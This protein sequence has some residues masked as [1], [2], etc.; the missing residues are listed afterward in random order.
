MPARRLQKA[1][2]GIQQRRVLPGR[3]HQH[4]GVVAGALGRALLQ[5]G[6][7]LH[8]PRHTAVRRAVGVD[9]PEPRVRAGDVLLH[10]PAAKIT[11]PRRGGKELPQPGGV[12]NEI[13]LAPPR[14][15]AA[16]VGRLIRGLGDDRPAKRQ[17]RQGVRRALRHGLRCA[18][19][20]GAAGRSKL[21]LIGQMHRRG[22]RA[23]KA[24]RPAQRVGMAGQQ[25]RVVVGAGDENFGHAGVLRRQPQQ[26]GRKDMVLPER[27]VLH[28][29][30]HQT[31][32]GQRGQG[33]A[34]DGQAAHAI[35]FIKAAGHAV[36]IGIPAQQHQQHPRHTNPPC[37]KCMR[38]G[39]NYVLF[40]FPQ[41]G[42]RPQARVGAQPPLGGS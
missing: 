26:R 38:Q 3:L 18:Q 20:R 10:E 1:A 27:R 6:L 8:K 9:D 28:S 15:I 5:K 36:D 32:V 2:Q 22:R 33:A 14:E 34:A 7:A 39:G 13:H 35:A 11:A 42:L 41:V 16:G 12:L 23:G 21:P 31:A 4:G 19:P 25:G 37:R 24:V 40:A 17:R 29:D 30:P